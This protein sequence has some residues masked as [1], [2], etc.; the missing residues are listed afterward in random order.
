MSWKIWYDN[1][2]TFSSED[3]SPQLAPG[4]GVICIIQ[5]SE[6]TGRVQLSGADYYTWDG[7]W[8]RRDLFGLWDYLAGKGWKT[9]KFGRTID[10]LDYE[11]ILRRAEQDTTFPPRS[12]WEP[13]EH[14]ID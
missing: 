10:R 2:S 3:G 6:R 14:R 4:R 9:V 5:T 13:W 11:A 7:S 12:A 8:T 1:G